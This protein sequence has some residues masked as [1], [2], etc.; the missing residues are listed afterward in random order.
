MPIR[1]LQS[2]PRHYALTTPIR[3]EYIATPRDQVGR[4]GIVFLATPVLAQI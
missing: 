2:D 4:G 1:S 3:G